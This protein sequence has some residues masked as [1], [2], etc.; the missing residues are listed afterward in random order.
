MQRGQ[1]FAT[2]YVNSRKPNNGNAPPQHRTQSLLLTTPHRQE[3]L[4]MCS[5][6]AWRGWVMAWWT[7]TTVTG[8]TTPPTPCPNENDPK[9]DLSKQVIP[10]II[11][12]GAPTANNIFRLI[13]GTR[14]L[15]DDEEPISFQMQ[16]LMHT[17]QD[18]WHH[19]PTTTA[20]IQHPGN[21]VPTSAS[22]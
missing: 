11:G 9:N 2:V 4:V 5:G 6:D 12:G 18:L 20:G 3:P 8:T 16:I 13:C 10:I 21:T 15:V 22:A 14:V 17:V 7:T 19:L 1:T